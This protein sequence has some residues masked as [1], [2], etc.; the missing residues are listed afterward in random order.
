MIKKLLISFF[1]IISIGATAVGVTRA[2][3]SDQATLAANTFST[4]TVDLKVSTSQSTAPTSFTDQVTGFTDKIFPGQT[5]TELFWLKNNST[6]IGFSLAAQAASVSGAINPSD[7]TI[8]FT[9]VDING[10]TS[11]GSTVS[12]TLDVWNTP[13]SL[14]TTIANGARQ[15]YKMEVT[16]SSNVATSGSVVFDFNFTG[17]QTP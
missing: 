11:V 7:V 3:L 5:K 4:G 10:V 12:H 8:A 13:D 2:S 16:L 17:T 1:I 6:D 9:P 15:R 14:G